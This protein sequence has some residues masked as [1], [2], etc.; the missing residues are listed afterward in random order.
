M[1]GMAPS[2]GE[3]AEVVIKN[4]EFIPK[5]LEKIGCWVLFNIFF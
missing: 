5:W 1:S 3:E 4:F 2:N